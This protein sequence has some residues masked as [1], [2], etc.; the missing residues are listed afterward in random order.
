MASSIRANQGD[1]LS[2]ICWQHYGTTAGGIVEQVLEA[3]PGLAGLGPLLP[4]GT[5]IALPE[6]APVTNIEELIQLWD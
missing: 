5:L 4:M 1:T 2:A 3:N 6:L